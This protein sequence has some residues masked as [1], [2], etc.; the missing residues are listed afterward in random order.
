[1]VFCEYCLKILSN[2]KQMPNALKEWNLFQEALILVYFH[3]NRSR[4]KKIMINSYTLKGFPGGSDSKESTCNVGNLILIPGLGRSPGGGY[5]Y[6]LQYSYL[7]NPHGQRSL[8]GDCSWGCKELDW[9]TKQTYN[10]KKILG[11]K[12]N[13]LPDSNIQDMNNKCIV[14]IDK[15]ISQPQSQLRT[16]KKCLIS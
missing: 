10:T 14:L 7:E 11:K 2:S 12:Q 3:F 1:M 5:G 8:V 13:N 16:R 4:R 6:P 9:M 15:N